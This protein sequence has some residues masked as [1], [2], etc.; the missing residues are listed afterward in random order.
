[1]DSAVSSKDKALRDQWIY[2][3]VPFL[4]GENNEIRI[5]GPQGSNKTN[6]YEEV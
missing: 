1:M 3:E 6:T 4:A 5:V 2:H